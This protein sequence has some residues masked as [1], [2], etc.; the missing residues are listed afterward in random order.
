MSASLNNGRVFISDDTITVK[1]MF[2][3]SI[4]I[5]KNK[6]KSVNK[7]GNII[8]G[9]GLCIIIFGLPKGLKMLSGKRLI[10]VNTYSEKYEFWLTNLD[11]R[12]LQDHL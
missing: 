4:I 1:T 8:Y 2:G 10:E 5:Q 3:S 9:I 7:V 6:I 12:I 11:Y